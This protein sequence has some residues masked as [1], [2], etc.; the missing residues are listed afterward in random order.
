MLPY[1]TA[2]DQAGAP[3]FTYYRER[4]IRR[5]AGLRWSGRCPRGHPAGGQRGLLG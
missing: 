2:F 3:T 5:L 4:L 1:H